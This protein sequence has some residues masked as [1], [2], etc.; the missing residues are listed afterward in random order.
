MKS[1]DEFNG[2]CNNAETLSNLKSKKVWNSSASSQEE[3]CTPKKED[4]EK[5]PI[6]YDMRPI[7]IRGEAT[8]LFARKSTGKSA[9]SCSIAARVIA[10]D[11]SSRPVP[12]LRE[13]WWTVPQ[14]GHKVLYLDFENQN[15]IEQKQQLFQDSYFPNDKQKECHSNLIMKDLSTSSKNFSVLGNQQ[16]VLDMIE[17]AKHEGTP[18]LPIDLLI[19]DT[20]TGFV[21]TETPATPGNFKLLV[22]KIRAMR[23]AVWVVRHANADDEA[24]GFKSKL[25]PFGFTFRIYRDDNKPGDLEEQP[26]SV[27]YGDI[28]GEMGSELRK[29]F[30]IQYNN[31]NHQWNVVNPVRSEDDELKLII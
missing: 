4:H 23:I 31:R 28:R 13:K 15:Q 20:Y 25:Y 16:E 6:D 26:I 3:T 10:A 29:P 1:E 21:Q 19:I 5:S 18:G 17:A 27:E 22:D 9:L 14:K 8:M 24:G 12:L 11:A 2:L 7:L 30:Q